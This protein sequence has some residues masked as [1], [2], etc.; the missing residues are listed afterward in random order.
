MGCVGCIS[1]LLMSKATWYACWELST[2]AL[3]RNKEEDEFE[4]CHDSNMHLVCGSAFHHIFREYFNIFPYA[5][6]WSIRS[7]TSHDD[8]I[9]C[10]VPFYVTL[11]ELLPTYSSL[12]LQLLPQTG[13]YN[14]RLS[15][16]GRKP[17]SQLQ[18][19]WQ[20][21][22]CQEVPERN[23]LVLNSA[24]LPSEKFKKSPFTG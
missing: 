21:G 7:F 19:H 12:R 18:S 22:T 20:L 17:C 1:F 23:V 13:I 16:S 6:I 10:I 11:N 2:V 9:W 15:F 3:K 24:Y 5:H 4:Q 8:V 14:S